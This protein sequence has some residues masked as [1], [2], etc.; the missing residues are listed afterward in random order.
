M[1]SHGCK[2]VACKVRLTDDGRNSNHELCEIA[3][4]GRREEKSECDRREVLVSR[5][6]QP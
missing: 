1:E 6:S 3:P 4:L 5:G 2:M